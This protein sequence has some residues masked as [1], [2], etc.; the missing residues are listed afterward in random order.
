MEVCMNFLFIGLGHE[1]GGYE[2]PGVHPLYNTRGKGAWGAHISDVQAPGLFL[3][4]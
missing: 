4:Q 1:Y 3:F 2:G